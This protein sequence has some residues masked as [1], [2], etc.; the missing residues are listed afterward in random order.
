MA[1]MPAWELELWAQRLSK[2]PAIQ[3]KQ[4][5]AIALL[6][7][8]YVNGKQAKGKKA[9]TVKDFLVFADAWEQTY[10]PN[11]GDDD[12][13]HDIKLLMASFASRLEIKQ[14]GE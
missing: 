3:E 13:D 4:A 7:A 6:C 5:Y 14:P 2:E 12:V 10:T 8:L 9:K 11:S 1:T